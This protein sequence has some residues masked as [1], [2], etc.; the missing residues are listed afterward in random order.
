M[1]GQSPGGAGRPH[2][3]GHDAGHMAHGD[4]GGH[5]RHAGH[6]EGMF[7][8]HF[9]ISLALTIPVLAYS[10]LL[11]G[12]LGYQA[13]ALPSSRWLAPILASIIYWYGGWPFLVGARRELGGRL[14]GMMTLVA[15]A[16][17][18]AYMYSLAIDF[19]LVQG[20]AFYWELAIPLVI[21][22]STT[23]SAKNGILVRDRLALEE[24]RKLDVV[25]FDK[26]GT[27]TRREQG[28]AGIATANGVGEDEA[29]TLAAAVER[30]S[31]H[32]IAR[33]IV[34]A[35]EERGLSVPD[36][37]EF[38]ALPGRGVQAS[39]VG[40]DLQLGGPRLLEHSNVTVPRELEERSRG[41]GEQ[42]QTVV[43]LLERDRVIAAL[44]MAD[45]IRPESREA[46]S[47]LEAMGIR[48]VM[49]TGDSEEVARWVAG[50]LGIGTYFAEVLPEHKSEK[51]KALRQGGATVGMVGDGVNDA[52]ALAQ[53]NVGIAIGAGTDVARA[54]AGIVLVKNDPRDVVKI[55]ELSRASYSKMVQNLVWAVGYNAIALPL[56]A[57]VFAGLGFVLPLWVGAV[58]M[59]ASTIIVALNAQTQRRLELR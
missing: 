21:A 47:A 32:I 37:E 39:V 33:A 56:A 53:A 4:K 20:M 50:E 29:L 22:I 48:V 23:L 46:V 19:G 40:R 3:P 1:A 41:W 18:T 16:I 36:V 26:T 6:S 13:P 25:V 24:A 10:E 42:G 28:L 15:M 35:A 51:V 38:Q 2:R 43:Y 5:D 45:V 49:L 27:L 58:L 17:T 59:S 54:A 30:D 11:Q 55:V 57:G 8:N 14:P 44:A 34:R 31:E 12:L 7:Q 9:W 52:P